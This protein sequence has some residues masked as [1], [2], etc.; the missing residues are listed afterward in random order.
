MLKGDKS[1]NRAK[2]KSS[3][4]VKGGASPSVPKK[5]GKSDPTRQVVL[6]DLTLA[7][8]VDLSPLNLSKVGFRPVVEGPA[9]T[10]CGGEE[11]DE[12]ECSGPATGLR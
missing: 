4:T 2:V 1:T 10:K 6:D 11:C 7:L 8:L 9:T 3:K 12:E 5:R